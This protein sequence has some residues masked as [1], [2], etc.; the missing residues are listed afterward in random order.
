MFHGDYQPHR[1]LAIIVKLVLLV[2]FA[3]EEGRVIDTLLLFFGTTQTT[4]TI[5]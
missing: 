5:R 3:V 4:A 1:K 2:Q